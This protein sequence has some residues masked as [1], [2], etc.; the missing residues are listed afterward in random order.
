M[1][2]KN[3][4]VLALL[5]TA[6]CL[7]TL[8]ACSNIPEVSPTP[9]GS[10]TPDIIDETALYVAIDGS[11]END[12]SIA[13][14]FAT[15]EKA[16]ETVKNIVSEGLTKPVTV[17]FRGG[18][19][20]VNN[21]SFTDDMSGTKEFP[22]T[23]KAY[24]DEEVVFNGGMTFKSSDYKKVTDEAIL[25]RL[26]DD[27]KDK[28]LY[29]DLKEYGLT[30]DDIGELY[31]FGTYTPYAEYGL[32]RGANAEL[33][34][35]DSRLTLARYP[36]EGYLDIDGIV[37]EGVPG[38][39]IAG[40]TLVDVDSVKR[41]KNWK[42]IDKAE[43]FGYWR[44]KWAEI[45]SP[46]DYFNAETRE[47][48]CKYYS[49]NGYNKDIAKYYFYNVL[50]ELDIPGEYYIDRDNMI[51]YV[52]PPEGEENCDSII[53]ISDG[54]MLSGK[55]S[56]IVFENFAFKGQRG[57]GMNFTGDNIKVLNCKFSCMYNSAAH[58]N[59]SNNLI[60]GCEAY[61]LGK[62][63]FFITGGDR[64]TLT[65]GNSIIENCYIHN[66][67]EVYTTYQQACFAKGCGNQIIHNEIAYAPHLAL[68][69]TGNEHLIAYNYIHDVVLD[70]DDAGAL[71]VGGDW[72]SCG[73]K[74]M[75]NLFENI[76]HEKGDCK[77]IYYDDGM[78]SGYVFGNVI[79]NCSGV[80]INIGGGRD[81]VIENNL[82]ISDGIPFNYDARMGTSRNI[83]N[84]WASIYWKIKPGQGMWANLKQVPYQGE[85]WSERYPN[86]AL[87][88]TDYERYRDPEFPGNPAYSIVKNNIF[89]GKKA[90]GYRDQID[91]DVILYSDIGYNIA[92]NDN[93]EILEK[94]SY[95]IDE[96][97]LDLYNILY[98][99]EW[100][101]IPYDKIGRYISEK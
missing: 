3:R 100:E 91:G 85:L 31:Q 17:Y 89:V 63:G 2:K 52:Y 38:E 26:L 1:I 56:N 84:S 51:L 87:I 95:K 21:I 14:P 54:N 77:A 98:G 83:E 15:I 19:Y 32:K 58:L 92:V 8:T 34:W 48:R 45:T 82:V 53:S 55:V 71:Y 66:F 18:N 74:V 25:S 49:D 41:M 79:I 50:E 9:D 93:S 57:D 61:S 76:G 27:V 16:L 101:A 99:V 69:Y 20:R 40:T 72:T 37:D 6:A 11:D 5:L 36:N 43:V 47:L 35:N 33:F 42:E 59:G 24:Q 28:V 12:G 39:L 13:S 75:Y 70:S 29:L 86:L 78:S 30:I 23:F 94:D 22:V 88:T 81:M 67:S 97:Y 10:P 65:N 62:G 90:T 96:Y 7:L 60:F 73:T 46:I 4:S 68:S 80:G 44:F 64:Q